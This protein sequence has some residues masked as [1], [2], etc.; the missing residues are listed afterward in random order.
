MTNVQLDHNSALD[1][2][3][4]SRAGYHFLASLCAF[5][6][7]APAIWALY[8]QCS[9]LRPDIFRGIAPGV[10]WRCS[11]LPAQYW[12]RFSGVRESAF[13]DS[14]SVLF[15]WAVNYGGPLA[16]LYTL[17]NLTLLHIFIFYLNLYVLLRCATITPWA[18]YIG[19]SVGML[20]RNTELYASWITISASYAWLPLVLAGGVLLLRFPG[21]TSGILVFSIAAG[22]LALAS[23]LP[24][25][26]SCCPSCLILFAAGIAW[27]C[28]QRRFA[29]V[30]RV[31]WSLVLCGGI[32]FG[33]AGVAILPMYLATGEMIRHI[34]AGASVIG[35]AHI[36]WENFNLHS[37]YVEPG[38]RY[39]RQ[40]DLDLAS[41]AVLT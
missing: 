16:S 30:W 2:L 22:L 19:A 1:K 9:H 3:C 24:A 6:S 21:K 14:L 33:L 29:D 34:G 25:S 23:R 31:V 28:L 20:A 5:F 37:T 41:S 26:D 17:T 8:R 39:C 12:D 35:H 4:C 15:F 10:V 7:V 13:F 36:P 38:N 40:T 27:L 32:A 18:S 11:V